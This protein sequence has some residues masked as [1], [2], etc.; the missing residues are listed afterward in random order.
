MR[1]FALTDMERLGAFDEAERTFQ[2]TE[3][4]FR[5]FYELTARPVRVY[6]A[7]MTGD[8]RLSDD[9]LQETY[10]RFLR[11][12]R[13]F[14]SDDHRRNYLPHRDEP[15]HDHRRKPFMEVPV[16]AIV[17]VPDA[18]AAAQAAERAAR[19]LDLERAMKQLKPRERSMLWLAYAQGW[20][21]EEIASAIG[22]KT[23]SMK[24]IA[25]NS[26]AQG[27]G[28]AARRRTLMTQAACDCPRE[29][30]VVNA[31]LA[32]HGPNAVT[33]RWSPMPRT[34]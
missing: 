28:S 23:A 11:A 3:E 18:A 4:A 16:A 29:Q 27:P 24:A 34:V 5:A 25:R 31:V 17:E 7:R 33:I 13:A 12:N 2:M 19:R 15:G 32:K 6:L 20:S 14:D 26:G 30:D 8:D 22:V 1:D 9:L 10:Y 21:H